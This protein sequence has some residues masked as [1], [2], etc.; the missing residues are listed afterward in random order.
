MRLLSL[1]LL[2]L[3][4]LSLLLLIQLRLERSYLD[5]SSIIIVPEASPADGH[6]AA[7]E[8]ARLRPR[9]DSSR[10]PCSISQRFIGVYANPHGAYAEIEHGEGSA[11][12]RF[13]GQF[14]SERRAAQ[15]Y[16]RAA[17]EQHGAGATLN[18]GGGGSDSDSGSCDDGGGGSGG[19]VSPLM[20]GAGGGLNDAMRRS[21]ASDS[22][23][24]GG[25]GGGG[26]GAYGMEEETESD[27]EEGGGDGE[28]RVSDVDETNTTM[29]SAMVRASCF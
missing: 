21:H 20:R 29:A 25:G 17:L 22:L 6:A 28:G 14:V 27:G 8:P 24:G 3:P 23:T 4:L 19:G 11:E 16:D 15:A 13:L 26:A 10:G 5:Q 1:L 7:A 12:P 2:L 9:L 18:F